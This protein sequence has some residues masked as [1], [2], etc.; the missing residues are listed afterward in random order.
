[1]KGTFEKRPGSEDRT[2]RINVTFSTREDMEAFDS[3]VEAV[4]DGKVQSWCVCHPVD[5]VS[6]ERL[7]VFAI[8]KT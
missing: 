2:P 4:R 7:L 1:M 8:A 6:L 5:G 3:F